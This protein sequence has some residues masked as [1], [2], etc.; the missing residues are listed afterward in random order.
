MRVDRLFCLWCRFWI[1]RALMKQPIEKAVSGFTGS[2]TSLNVILIDH[3]HKHN[4]TTKKTNLRNCSHGYRTDVNQNHKRAE[5]R[6]SVARLL[7]DYIFFQIK[8]TFS[9]QMRFSRK[10]RIW[11]YFWPIGNTES[12]HEFLFYFPEFNL[13]RS[14]REKKWKTRIWKVNLKF[15][16]P[17]KT[18]FYRFSNICI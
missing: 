4:S 17:Q 3:G 11:K 13:H 12:V 1:C 15:I 7:Y 2:S 9:H 6:D 10:F 14:A 8:S 18:Y 16:F 5:R